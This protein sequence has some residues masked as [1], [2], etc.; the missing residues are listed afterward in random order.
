MY[1]FRSPEFRKLL[2]PYAA[3]LGLAACTYLPQGPG[4]MTHGYIELMDAAASA[5]RAGLTGMQD[6]ARSRHRDSA[7]PDNRLRLALL[8]SAPG[9][10]HDDV[11]QSVDLLQPLADGS[12]SANTNQRQL[13]RA[14]LADVRA[15]LALLSDNADKARQLDSLKTQLDDANAKID[16]LLNIEQSMESGRRRESGEDHDQ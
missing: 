13:A 9:A 11:R 12:A 14:R 6:Q 15:R 10:R 8:L 4:E 2:V 1:G 3:V 7:T 5:D 16:E